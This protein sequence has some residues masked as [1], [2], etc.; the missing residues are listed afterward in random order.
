MDLTA[1]SPAHFARDAVREDRLL[2]GRVRLMQPVRGY[3]AALDPVLLAAA[4]PARPGERVLELGCGVGAATF[5]LA[6]RVGELVL[7]GLEIQPDYLQ[8]A[9]ENARL[10]GVEVALHEGDVAA[11]PPALRRLAFDQVM[12]NPPYQG[13]ATVPSPVAGRDR[14]HRESGASLGD[15]IAAGLSRLRP[16]GWLTVIHRAERVPEMLRSLDGPAGSIDLKP[17]VP[18]AGRAAKRVILRARKGG[19]GPF[20]LLAP[21]V[22][23]AGER[24]LRDEEDFTA[25]ATALLRNAAALDFQESL[26]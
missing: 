4:V 23:H 22:L 16:R 3:R 21:L 5:C 12:L 26:S 7:H 1:Q 10:N 25:E 6:A 20:R 2:A 17:L 13:A 8:L 9:R 15:W 11:M 18:R 19:K 24:H 14:A